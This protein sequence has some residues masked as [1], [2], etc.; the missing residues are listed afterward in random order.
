[1]STISIKLETKPSMNIFNSK[2]NVGEERVVEIE[3]RSEEIIQNKA[4]QDNK[5]DN[6]EKKQ[7]QMR[8]K[9]DDETESEFSK[10]VENF[11]EQ[12]LRYS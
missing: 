11:T 7:R 12:Y 2:L 1:M 8:V 4:K 9:S 3:N 5:M 6:T 10:I